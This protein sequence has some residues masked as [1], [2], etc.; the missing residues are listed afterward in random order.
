M[1]KLQSNSG[2]YPHSASLTIIEGDLARLAPGPGGPPPFTAQELPARYGM[3]LFELLVVDP[4]FAFVSWEIT[5]AQL[6]QARLDLGAELFE[7]RRLLL[8][9]VLEQQP[10]VLLASRELYGDTGRWFV[11]LSQPDTWLRAELG[12]VAGSRWHLLASAGPVLMP[13]TE[14]VDGDFIELQVEYGMAPD[15]QLTLTSSGEAGLL[16][17]ETIAAMALNL[18]PAGWPGGSGALAPGGSSAWSRRQ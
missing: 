1:D 3:A 6:E 4:D 2:Q 18:D 9:F 5:D 13:R 7:Q 10:D 14:P 16:R 15:G 8:R 17:A 12:F 11:E